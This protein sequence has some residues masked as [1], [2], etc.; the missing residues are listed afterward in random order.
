MSIE[1]FNADDSSEVQE[2]A[3]LILCFMVERYEEATVENCEIIAHSISQALI[4]YLAGHLPK[5][6]AIKWIEANYEARKRN[7]AQAS[8]FLKENGFNG[9]ADSKT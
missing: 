9:I 6:S 7:I 5:E 4:L 8:I 2:N 3:I 1:I